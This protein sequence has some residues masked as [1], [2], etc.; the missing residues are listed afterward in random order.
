MVVTNLV[1]D[2]IPGEPSIVDDDVDF[3]SELHGLLH[4]SLQILVV[5]HVAGNGNG[6]AGPII[7]DGLCD[8]V[9]PLC[10]TNVSPSST[11]TSFSHNPHPP[12]NERKRKEG[13]PGKT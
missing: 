4:H 12:R 7:I 6:S 9:G 10:L 8:R 1:D 3:P 13:K 5:L 2:S 11:D